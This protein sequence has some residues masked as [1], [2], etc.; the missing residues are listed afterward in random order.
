MWL[1]WSL[2]ACWR[3]KSGPGPGLDH[4]LWPQFRILD[5]MALNPKN[6]KKVKKV[7][8]SGFSVFGPKKMVFKKKDIST[9][10]P[11]IWPRETGIFKSKKKTRFQRGIPGDAQLRKMGYR[12]KRAPDRPWAFR[13]GIPPAVVYRGTPP[14]NR[15]FLGISGF[16]WIFRIFPLFDQ[17]SGTHH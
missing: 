5:E 7:E 13:R 1:K 6:M 11:D 12:G 9:P 10:P 14:E 8:K 16:F 3:L 17:N 15:F 2:L 4:G